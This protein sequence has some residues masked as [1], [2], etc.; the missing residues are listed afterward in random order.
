MIV[1][2]ADTNPKEYSP[3]AVPPPIASEKSTHSRH[4]ITANLDTSGDRVRLCQITMAASS[5]SSSYL[6]KHRSQKCRVFLFSSRHH[7]VKSR[8]GTSAR[9]RK[10]VGC[11]LAEKQN[12]ANA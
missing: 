9:A 2:T 8:S 4:D 11:A 5:E 6:M 7:G 3:P 12:V 1:Q 10:T